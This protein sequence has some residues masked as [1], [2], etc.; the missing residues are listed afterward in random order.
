MK[1]GLSVPQFEA[2]GN[3][4]RLADLAYVAGGLG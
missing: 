3:V 2:F 4:K 1:F